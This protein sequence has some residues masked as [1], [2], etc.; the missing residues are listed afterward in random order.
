M[1]TASVFS[2]ITKGKGTDWK[3]VGLCPTPPQGEVRPA[4]PARPAGVP[5]WAAPS[6]AQ[7]VQE[8]HEIQEAPLRGD[9]RGRP[10]KPPNFPSRVLPAA[11]G[12]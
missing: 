5:D 7:E 1:R 9:G 6:G 8:V 12:P 3:G 4:P 10:I 2:G 11:A